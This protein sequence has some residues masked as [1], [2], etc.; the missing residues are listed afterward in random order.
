MNTMTS[1]RYDLADKSVWR[2][3]Y[4]AMQ[5]AGDGVSVRPAIAMKRSQCCGPPPTPA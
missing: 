2:V 1:D 4:G 5:L 3:G